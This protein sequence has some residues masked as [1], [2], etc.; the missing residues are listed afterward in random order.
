[1]AREIDRYIFHEKSAAK[2]KMISNAMVIVVV[3]AD[4]RYAG[5]MGET[6]LQG[7]LNNEI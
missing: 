5:F 1:M 4:C 2:S 6:S 3:E 7:R